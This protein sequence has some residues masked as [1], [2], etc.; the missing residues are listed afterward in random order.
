M[1][2]ERRL[3]YVAMTRAIEELNIYTW[4]PAMSKFLDEI[5]D[6]TTKIRLNY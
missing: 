4:Q 5:E 1:E 2:E 3:F 6:F